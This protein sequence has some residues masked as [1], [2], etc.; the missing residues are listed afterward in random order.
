MFTFGSSKSRVTGHWSR[1]PAGSVAGVTSPFFSNAGTRVRRHAGTVFLFFLLFVTACTGIGG[2]GSS[3]L[4]G[5]TSGSTTSDEGGA[6]STDSGS[7][8]D[9]GSADAMPGGVPIALP[10][11]TIDTDKII[12]AA[13]AVGTETSTAASSPRHPGT[14]ALWHLSKLIRSA[15]AASELQ[16]HVPI[17]GYAGAVSST[18]TY[19]DGTTA[20]MTDADL[21]GYFDTYQV[22]VSTAEITD[23]S[24]NVCEQSGV[25]CV[26]AATDG[27]FEAYYDDAT[28]S[29]TFYVYLTDGTNLSSAISEVPNTNFLWFRQEPKD[30]TGGPSEQS[31]SDLNLTD[32]NVIWSLGDD[33]IIPVIEN[34]GTFMVVGNYADYYEAD[35]ASGATG[36]AFGETSYLSKLNST[37]GLPFDTFDSAYWFGSDFLRDSG[38]A[39]VEN[40]E[41]YNVVKKSN[42]GKLRFVRKP[43]TEILETLDEEFIYYAL[44]TDPPSSSESIPFFQNTDSDMTGVQVANTHVFDAGSSYA[45]ALFE[46]QSGN[47]R[48]R[49]VKR[50]SST[51]FG[52]STA[53]STDVSNTPEFKDMV[54]YSEQTTSSTYTYALLLDSANN[55]VWQIKARYRSSSSQSVTSEL[56]TSTNGIAV[57]SNPTSIV[58]NEDKTKAYV[59]NQTDKTVSVITVMDG[60]TVRS[61]ASIATQTINLSDY[62]NGKDLTMTPNQLAYHQNP[63]S[64]KEYLVVS[65]Q[66][67]KG[68]IVVDLSAATL[69]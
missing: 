32:A 35:T 16:T 8:S 3:G 49:A 10:S 59:L 15:W 46:D 37:D 19:D 50:S 21:D 51:R 66:S 53:I 44:T 11:L 6:T 14:W 43:Q 20:E 22:A 67:L 28:N 48:L 18:I 4:T 69:N 9:A 60:T 25:V 40:T 7:G 65:D 24:T 47:K 38:T 55:M 1:L 12:A 13:E 58:L 33:R 45:L 29:T 23:T 5:E 30:V 42:D 64:E 26:S 57:G 63:T 52:G 2:T 54:I 61:Y 34:S 31:V 62:L 27:S 36:I 68:S 17:I 41:A 39:T 56:L